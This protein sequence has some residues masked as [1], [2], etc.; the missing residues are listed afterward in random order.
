MR[1]CVVGRYGKFSIKWRDPSGK[2]HWRTIG[3]SKRLAERAL[4]EVLGDMAKQGAAYR[5]EDARFDVF[6]ERY[7]L[8]CEEGGLKAST[9]AT[10]RNTSKRLT[11]YFGRVKMRN[12]VTVS[13]VQTYVSH[14]LASGD[15]PKT[16]NKCLW[17]LSGM[18]EAATAEGILPANP[19]RLVRKPR[20]LRNT[21]RTIVLPE[22]TAEILRWVVPEHKPAITVLALTA[23]RPSE[24]TGL[25]FETD[26]DWS[27][28]ELVIQRAAWRGQLHLFAKQ[29]RV[30][31]VPFGTQVREILEAQRASALSS[32]HGTV[33]S[34]RRGG[35]LDPKVLNT[36]FRDA[37][38]RAG[39]A[40]PDGEA[41]LYLLRHQACSQMLRS[42][43]A[44]TVSRIAGNSIRTLLSTYS[45]SENE[46]AH[47]AIRSLG[48]AV[49]L[50]SESL[51]RT[52]S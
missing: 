17:L 9:V 4:S 22:Q 21:E 16:V 25:I 2:Q 5:H 46:T 41:T 43:D 23:L 27:A 44:A 24:L 49:S 1:G 15:S 11:A 32:R 13:S 51:K 33:F 36:A 42:H 8:V 6:M 29:N 40:I 50:D 37:L 20:V 35:V 28:N 12:G 34:G 31:R 39:I 26:I 45:H 19:V 18:C 7:L 10:Y 38:R 47:D 3:T 30:R 48:A 52:A 14:R